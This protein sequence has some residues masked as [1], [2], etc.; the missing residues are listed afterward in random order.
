[1]NM[2]SKFFLGEQARVGE[3][4]EYDKMNPIFFSPKNFLSN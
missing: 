1:M 3:F 2:S 4:C